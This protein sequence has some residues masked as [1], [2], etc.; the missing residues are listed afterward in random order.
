MLTHQNHPIP[1]AKINFVDRSPEECGRPAPQLQA[2]RSP[3]LLRQW[4]RLREL[5]PKS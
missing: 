3:D 4:L 2:L 1:P 5:L